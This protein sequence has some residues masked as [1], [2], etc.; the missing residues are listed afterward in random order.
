M[1]NSE[2]S[3]LKYKMIEFNEPPNII[4]NKIN[5]EGN[6][7]MPNIITKNIRI[8]NNNPINEINSKK[9]QPKNVRYIKKIKNK[10]Y[11]NKTMNIHEKKDNIQ[12]SSRNTNE[13]IVKKE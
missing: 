1:E 7:N 9:V 8:K 4:L 13:Y 2:Y 5:T 6:Y 12:N 10:I 11:P 3:P